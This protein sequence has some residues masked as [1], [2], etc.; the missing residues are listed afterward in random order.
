MA[1]AIFVVLIFP[2]RLRFFILV[3]L[4]DPFALIIFL[5]CF[6]VMDLFEILVWI[7][8]MD[9]DLY[10]L[11]GTIWSV[12]ASNM[13]NGLEKGYISTLIDWKKPSFRSRSILHLFW[14][15]KGNLCMHGLGIWLCHRDDMGIYCMRGGSMTNEDNEKHAIHD[16]WFLSKDL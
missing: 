11:N 7:Q 15:Q 8:I 2:S 14:N 13:R 1:D 3:S 4:D 6:E 9:L 5:W 12:R 16:G 10:F